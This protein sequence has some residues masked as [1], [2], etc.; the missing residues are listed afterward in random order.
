LNK[1]KSNR[2]DMAQYGQASKLTRPSKVRFKDESAHC[3]K[4]SQLLKKKNI[5]GVLRVEGGSDN[6]R[7]SPKR[8]PSR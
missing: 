8:G 4:A 3:L 2:A 7:Q 6:L 5:R 1:Q